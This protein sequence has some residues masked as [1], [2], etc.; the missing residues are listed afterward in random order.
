MHYVLSIVYSS[1]VGFQ[2]SI[3]T[4]VNWNA[5]T[6][7]AARIWHRP[8]LE[9]WNVNETCQNSTCSNRGIHHNAW[10]PCGSCTWWLAGSCLQLEAWVSKYQSRCMLFLTVSCCFLS[11]LVVSCRFLLFLVVSCCLV[12]GLFLAIALPSPVFRSLISCSSIPIWLG[13]RI[14]CGPKTVGSLVTR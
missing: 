11:F 13:A 5:R 7:T 1:T 10:S 6:T 2:V 12:S 8:H 3:G 4:L 9:R 14:A